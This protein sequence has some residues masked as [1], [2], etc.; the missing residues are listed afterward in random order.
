VKIIFLSHIFCCESYILLY[1]FCYE[2]CISD[3]TDFAIKTISLITYICYKNY[4]FHYRFFCKKCISNHIDFA[5]KTISLFTYTIVTSCI[6]IN[7]FTAIAV[8]KLQFLASQIT[9]LDGPALYSSAVLSYSFLI[10]LP[11]ISG[12]DVRD[13]G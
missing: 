6:F 2:N 5:I 12:L 9:V 10:K 11:V 4:I 13:G 1:I 3:H 7:I 8:R